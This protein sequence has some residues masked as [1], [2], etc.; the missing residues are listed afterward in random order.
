M[1]R[2]RAE[3]FFDGLAVRRNAEIKAK[4]KQKPLAERNLTAFKNILSAIEAYYDVIKTGI[5]YKE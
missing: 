5:E 2:A 4:Q 1:D 3:A